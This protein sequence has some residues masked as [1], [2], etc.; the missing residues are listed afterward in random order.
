VKYAGVPG[1]LLA[2]LE[3]GQQA[4]I[5]VGVLTKAG[6]AGLIQKCADAHAV[7]NL[8]FLDRV[9]P[10]RDFRTPVKVFFSRTISSL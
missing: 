8:F 7:L 2:H 6:F 9:I 5:H 3:A 10:L 4:S 1:S